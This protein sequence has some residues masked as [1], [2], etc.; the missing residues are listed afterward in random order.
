MMQLADTIRYVV[1]SAPFKQ[2]KY[3]PATHLPI[4]APETLNSDPVDAVIVIAASY[5]DEV[6]R[7]L[8]QRFPGIAN[9]SILRNSR[10]EEA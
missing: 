3:T 1:D 10:L 8:R 5:S 6:V 7:I 4:V 9:V 2:G